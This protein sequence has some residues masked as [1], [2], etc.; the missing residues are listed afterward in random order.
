VAV[1]SP[2]GRRIACLLGAIDRPDARKIH[3]Q[4]TPRLGGLAAALA[5]ATCAGIWICIDPTAP[6]QCARYWGL[7]P[8]AMLMFLIG[9]YDDLFDLKPRT[10]LAFQFVAAAIIWYGGIRVQALVMPW[11]GYLHLG[12]A[13]AVLTVLWILAVTNALNLL[14]GLDGLAAGTAALASS[15]FLLMGGRSELGSLLGVI[16]AILIGACVVLVVNNCRSPK[17]FLGDSG[18]LLLGVML[19]AVSILA[20]RTT[21]PAP[22][23]GRADVVRPCLAVIPLAVPIVDM[24]ACM[25]RRTIIGRSIFAADRGH[26]HHLLLAIGMRPPAALAFLCMATACCG[27]GAATVIRL[28]VWKPGLSANVAETLLL[29]AT[30]SGFLILYGWL[31]CFSPN[32]WRRYRKAHRLIRRMAVCAS[33]EARCAQSVSRRLRR[34]CTLL[35]IR[36]LRIEPKA[37]PSA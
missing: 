6:D 17:L 2:W 1:A 11:I 21:V 30:L 16:S 24:L 27:L 4:A 26:I 32:M 12:P 37:P 22:D 19:A 34:L 9:F 3:T 35:R 28:P 15:C 25:I 10:K 20:T 29:A 13:G 31:G 36:Y 23:A 18:S 14:D 33:T 5:V 7:W 8:G